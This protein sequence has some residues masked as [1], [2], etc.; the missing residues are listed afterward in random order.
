MLGVVLLGLGGCTELGPDDAIEMVQ[1]LPLAVVVPKG[2]ELKRAEEYADAHPGHF[3]YLAVMSHPLSPY[4]ERAG[5]V[6]RDLDWHELKRGMTVV[7]LAQ[8]DGMMVGMGAGLLVEKIGDGWMY[9]SWGYPDVKPNLLTRV[10]YAGVVMLAFVSDE[11]AKPD[12]DRPMS[13]FQ[14]PNG[15]VVATNHPLEC[16]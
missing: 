1:Y 4:G 8:R 7:Y 10:A 5:I 11:K 15:P 2:D 9:R 3:A 16:E 13:N 12:G 14:D 6:A